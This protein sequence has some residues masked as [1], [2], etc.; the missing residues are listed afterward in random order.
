MDSEP[1]TGVSN[2]GDPG[3]IRNYADLRNVKPGLQCTARGFPVLSTRWLLVVNQG[4]HLLMNVVGTQE[5]Y[6]KTDQ[7]GGL[8]DIPFL[9]AIGHSGS[10]PYFA[11]FY[12]TFA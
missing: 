1:R 4:S 6:L 2:Q 8:I 10:I 9:T 11:G 7:V 12:P 3:K 5:V